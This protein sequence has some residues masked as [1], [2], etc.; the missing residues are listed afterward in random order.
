M[1]GALHMEHGPRGGALVRCHQPHPDTEAGAR[2]APAVW[3]GA[4][5]GAAFVSAFDLPP[6]HAG[7]ET[8]HGLTGTEKDPLSRKAHR[9][10]VLWGWWADCAPCSRC[11][12]PPG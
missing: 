12:T 10:R 5:L 4:G 6:I 1:H 7:G 2:S 8:T 11:H 3:A 9:S